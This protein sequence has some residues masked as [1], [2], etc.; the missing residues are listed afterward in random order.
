[1]TLWGSWNQISIKWIGLILMK[2][3]RK[4][5]ST[6]FKIGIAIIYASIRVRASLKKEAQVHW[7]GT[8]RS[9]FTSIL[10]RKG[11]IEA[12]GSWYLWCR[13]AAQLVTRRGVAKS[14]L[15]LPPLACGVLSPVFASNI[16]SIK[17]CRS[18]GFIRPCRASSQVRVM[19]YLPS[20]AVGKGYS[21]SWQGSRLVTPPASSSLQQQLQLSRLWVRTTIITI[22]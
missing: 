12:Q 19:E 4:M 11:Q 14:P 16:W 20:S 1:M 3:N 15:T 21:F 10:Y 2:E 7:T 5:R 18:P 8:K 6:V 17:L 22:F 9:T 13:S